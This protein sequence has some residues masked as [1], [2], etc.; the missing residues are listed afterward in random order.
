[1]KKTLVSIE[2]S[3][4]E[5]LDPDQG[6]RLIRDLLW[7]E[8]TRLKIS[9]Q[10]VV[11]SADITVADGGIDASIDAKDGAFDSVLVPGKCHYQIKTGKSF[12]PW[13]PAEIKK[14]L[15]GKHAVKRTNLGASVVACLDAGDTYTLITHGHDLTTEQRDAAVVL[16]VKAFSDCGFVNPNVIVLGVT[17]I[18]S[19]IVLHPSLCLELNGLGDL[20]FQ[21]ARSWAHNSD[22]TAILAMGQPQDDFVGSLKD[23]LDNPGIQHVRVVGEPGIGKSR[24]VLETILGSQDF[25]ANTLYVKQASDF[26]NSSLLNELIKPGRAYSVILV[27]DEC[28][29]ADRSEIW[30]A[31]KGKE[32]I[33]L[34]TIDHGPEKG[35]GAG[36]VTLH[37]PLLEVGQVETIL[38]SYIGDSGRLRNWAEWCGGSARVAHAL[39]ENL[40]DNPSDILREPA[41]VPIWERYISGYSQTSDDYSGRIVLRHIALFEKFGARS[42]V[43]NEAEFIAKLVARTDPSITPAKFDSVVAYYRQRKI[44]QGDRTL[45]IVPPALRIYLWTDWWSNYGA[46]ASVSAMMEGMPESLH[47]WFM[48]SFIYAHGS[49]S[50]RDVVKSVLHP[51]SGLFSDREFLISENGSAFVNVLAEA[52]PAA[53]LALLRATILS[54]TDDQLTELK[55]SRQ[56]FAW[57]LE[58]IAVWNEHF[59]QAAKLLLR[60]SFGDK[61]TNSNNAQGMFLGL[62]SSN[63]GP[64]EAPLQQRVAFVKELL[65]SVNPSERLMGVSA[66]RELMNTRGHGRMVGVEYQGLRPEIIFWRPKLWTDLIDPWRDAFSELMR[67]RTLGDAT[68]RTQV[69]KAVLFSIDQLAVTNVMHA[70]LIA[71][72]NELFKCDENLE[73]IAKLVVHRLRYPSPHAPEDFVLAL[74]TLSTKA[75]GVTFAER[76]RRYVL[77]TVWEDDYEQKDGAEVPTESAASIR[78]GLAHEAVRDG[79]VVPALPAL[80]ASFEYR[81]EQFGFDVASAQ[82]DSALDAAL[83][84]EIQSASEAKSSAFLSGFLRGVHGI[85]ADRWEKLADALLTKPEKWISLAVASSGMTPKIFDTLLALFQAGSLDVSILP[86]LSYSTTKDYVGI[87]N[88]RR[89]LAAMFE[90]KDHELYR[91]SIEIADRTLCRSATANIEDEALAFMILTDES[92]LTFRMD[93]MQEH[94]WY[95]LAKRFRQQFPGR[96]EEFLARLVRRSESFNGIGAHGHVSELASEI[97]KDNPS[98]AWPLIAAELLGEREDL[99]L[100]WLGEKSHYGSPIP[101]AITRFATSDIFAWIDAAP[102][103]RALAISGAVTPN[104]EAGPSG[105]LARGF[106][107]RYAELPHVGESLIFDFWTGSF[108]GPR[109]QKF[110]QK[111]DLARQWLSEIESLKI[112]DWLTRL[113]EALSTEIEHCMI[114]EER[115]F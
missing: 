87:E 109:S 3:T 6:V 17:Q 49:E 39:G 54:W 47:A 58:K 24:L 25:S 97:C 42:P 36:M 23:A 29:D 107:E 64:T 22:M 51:S 93:N 12:K 7:A 41:T 57:A 34:V 82:K 79:L 44:L 86:V 50:A 65:S 9:R 48:R 106:V 14:E 95:E 26:Q 66:S 13:Q 1:M 71:A 19:L 55:K 80:L 101:P 38:R 113:I 8:A 11:I 89:L 67:V 16:I 46:S 77:I 31:L 75:I 60:L 84:A 110:A 74:N 94:H 100:R 37:A 108:S 73:D 45:R 52:D 99:M 83:L 78:L 81:V 56:S 2:N 69:D 104:L 112:Q 61:S 15:F 35:G 72:L 32:S 102:G 30:R 70:E 10:H 114:W 40:R 76:L 43:Q 68:W 53:T 98:R 96:D 5:S 27:V 91:F 63:N 18:I 85:D 4:I 33:K 88:F 92:A 90:R 115:S 59:R 21:T 28:D 103:V 105:D 62:F 111:R 20:P